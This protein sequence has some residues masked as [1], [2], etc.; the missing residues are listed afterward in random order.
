MK[1]TEKI[2]AASQA[3]MGMAG[4]GMVI[5]PAYGGR[6]AL[7]HSEED[8]EGIIKL[9]GTGASV[10]MRQYKMTR[11]DVISRLNERLQESEK[12]N[13]QIGGILT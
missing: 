9:L 11:A 10:L 12:R 6:L 1:D 13:D 8:I 3:I 2:I 5:L 7:V 4:G